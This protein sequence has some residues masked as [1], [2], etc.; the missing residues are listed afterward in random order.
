MTVCVKDH[1]CLFGN[2]EQG[3]MKMNDAG[4][5]VKSW[6]LSIPDKYIELDEYI[7][8]PNHFHGIIKI[9]GADQCVCPDPSVCPEYSNETRKKGE[10]RFAPTKDN[11]MV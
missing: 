11:T 10:H 6:W 4:N 2:V 7:I 3:V 9:V 1:M 8:M 5:T